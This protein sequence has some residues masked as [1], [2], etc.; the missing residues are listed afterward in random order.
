[1]AELSSSFGCYNL[2]RNLAQKEYDKP[3]SQRAMRT[4]T[5]SHASEPTWQAMRGNMQVTQLLKA[6]RFEMGA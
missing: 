1:M 4:M 6:N 2:V 5:V 3:A